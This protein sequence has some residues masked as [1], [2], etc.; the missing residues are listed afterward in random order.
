[1]IHELFIDAEKNGMFPILVWRTLATFISV[2][3]VNP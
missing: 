3:I 2:Q 1:M